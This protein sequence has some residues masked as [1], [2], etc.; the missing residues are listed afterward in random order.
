MNEHL[1][2]GREVGE[3][4]R[5][6]GRQDIHSFLLD[7]VESSGGRLLYASDAN[8][9]PVYLGIQAGSDERVGV[10][11]YP[12]RI[13]RNT[14]RNR[15][16]DEVRGQLRYGS[17][18]SWE[19]AHP[20]AKDVCGVGVGLVGHAAVIRPRRLEPLRRASAEEPAMAVDDALQNALAFG[21]RF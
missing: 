5:V 11:V 16:A 2:A 10:L 4:Y 18:C 3:V 15:P 20:V 7:A 17:E 8:R 9:A 12:F 19:R 14:I 13:T 6:S 1:V 21:V